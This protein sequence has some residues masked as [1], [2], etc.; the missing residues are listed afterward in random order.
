MREY[1]A[2]DK[3]F[4]FAGC[5]IQYIATNFLQTIRV[6]DFKD[7]SKQFWDDLACSKKNILNN[8]QHKQD[9]NMRISLNIFTLLLSVSLVSSKVQ[10]NENKIGQI[11]K[12]NR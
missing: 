9:I 12:A 6:W 2:A 10:A 1:S 8:Q 3:K 4:K 11:M 7:F 5:G